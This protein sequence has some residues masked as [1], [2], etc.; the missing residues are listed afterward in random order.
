MCLRAHCCSLILFCRCFL[1]LCPGDGGADAAFFS[2][3]F[4]REVT[5]VGCRIEDKQGWR[6]TGKLRFL[7][8][9]RQ[10]TCDPQMLTFILCV[11]EKTNKKDNTRIL[12]RNGNLVSG[13]SICEWTSHRGVLGLWLN[14]LWP[15][16][17]VM[18]CLRQW[19]TSCPVSPD[20]SMRSRAAQK[21][22]NWCRHITVPE[23]KRP[24]ELT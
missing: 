20:G 6:I 12:T 24:R 14:A 18:C 1:A 23:S 4:P 5:A 16:I 22:P 2:S 13:T 17:N 3:Q 10:V 19:T 7:D 8:G 21:N 9:L 11:K 15:C